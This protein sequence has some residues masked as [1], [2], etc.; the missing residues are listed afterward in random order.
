MKR[1]RPRILFALIGYVFAM[2]ASF[3][4]PVLSNPVQAG[5]PVQPLNIVFFYNETDKEA[6]KSG[7]AAIG[8]PITGGPGA[9]ANIAKT[10]IYAKGS[11]FGTNPFLFRYSGNTSSAVGGSIRPIYEATYFCVGGSANPRIATAGGAGDAKVILHI[12]P[13]LTA[14][15]IDASPTSPR[16]VTGAMSLVSAE[17]NGSPRTMAQLPSDCRINGLPRTVTIP[18][19]NLL[20][21]ATKST[22]GPNLKT[23]GQADAATNAPANNQAGTASAG[24]DEDAASQCPRSAAGLG[25]IVCPFIGIVNDLF[26]RSFQKFIVGLM[27]IDPLDTSSTSTNL[28]GVWKNIRDLANVLF[29]LIFM[30]IVLANTLSFNV[31]AYT[32]KKMIPK[33]VAA[34]IMVQFSFIISAVLIDIFNI[35]GGGLGD[36]LSSLANIPGDQG[37]S[38]LENLFATVFSALI[39]V[40]GGIIGVVAVGSAIGTTG[41]FA[42]VAIGFIIVLALTA[43]FA[44]MSL[45]FS[46]MFRKLIIVMLIL[47]SPLAFAALVLPSTEKI[48]KVWIG[49]FIQILMMYP[50]IVFLFASATVLQQALGSSANDVNP[51]VGIP[52]LMAAVMPIV[53][54]FMVPMTFKWGG[55]LMSAGSNGIDSLVRG[56]IG[57]S[58]VSKFKDSEAYKVPRALRASNKLEKKQGQASMSGTLKGMNKFN[59]WK[60]GVQLRGDFLGGNQMIAVERGKFGLPTGLPKRGDYGDMRR[61]QIRQRNEYLDKGLANAA[62]DRQHLISLLDPMTKGAKDGNFDEVMKQ[63]LLYDQVLNGLGSY[64]KKEGKLPY[65]DALVDLTAMGTKMGKTDKDLREDQDWIMGIDHNATKA[66]PLA[67]ETTHVTNLANR[68]DIDETTGDLKTV[69]VDNNPNLAPRKVKVASTSDH[70]WHDLEASFGQDTFMGDNKEIAVDQFVHGLVEQRD[71]NGNV[72]Q[73]RVIDKLLAK[74]QLLLHTLH[75][76]ATRY[77]AVKTEAR[78]AIVDYGTRALTRLDALEVKAQNNNLN[79]EE[80]D[81]LNFATQNKLRA[82]YTFAAHFADDAKVYQDK[83]TGNSGATKDPALE[84]ALKDVGG[85]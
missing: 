80:A 69:H 16:S 41:A 6:I 28:Y 66:M 67:A 53:V 70:E 20:T 32:I 83:F 27:H 71:A 9:N 44:F 8:S 23:S 72:T 15:F 34:A 21:A 68:Q 52:E 63:P 10:A 51:S 12:I 75:T 81:E 17:Q 45:L 1:S 37:G 58:A 2:A 82:A 49:T 31:Q 79:A 48:F 59:R 62:L 38:F 22:W 54:C 35:I 19:Y 50:I 56:K 36:L 60:A 14:A 40:L 18:N 5:E 33:L 57:G 78:Q 7:L 4:I 84:Q 24:V 29:L 3:L 46:L 11:N 61:I 42:G 25:W 47:M 13:S 43:F 39:L 77:G 65:A 74:D 64:V 76:T 73:H 55:K 26:A 30:I 85:A